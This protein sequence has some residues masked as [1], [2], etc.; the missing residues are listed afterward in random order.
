[1]LK[2]LKLLA[3]VGAW[4]KYIMLYMTTVLVLFSICSFFL[5]LLLWFIT[6]SFSISFVS[7]IVIT[8]VSLIYLSNRI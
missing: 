3:K 6:G 7:S 8:A 1:M 4:E 5:F 2:Y